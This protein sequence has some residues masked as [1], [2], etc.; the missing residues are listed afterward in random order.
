MKKHLSI[1]CGVYYP[2]PSPT[3]LCAKHFAQLL[4]DDYDIDMICLSTNGKSE[5]VTT[6]D[7]VRV[8]TLSGKRMA[9][10]YNSS[11]LMK[12]VLHMLG[13]IQIK[14]TVLGNLS[15]FRTAIYKE[16]SYIHN[17]RPFD[18]IFSIC[19]PF[20]AHCAAMDFK[21]EYP[22]V[23][24]CA[25]T[26]DPYSAQNRRR[27]FA[28]SLE[29]LVNAERSVLAKADVLL[30]SEEVYKTRGELYV[31]HRNYRA[32]PYMLP[33]TGFVSGE[34]RF[35]NAQ[36]I[37]CVYAGRFY[38]DIRNPEPMLKAFTKLSDNRIKLH[39]FSKGCEGIVRKYAGLSENL[40]IHEQVPHDEIAEVYRDADILV[41]VS[42]AVAEFLPS[43]TFEYIASCKPIIS[44]Q[45]T[46][47]QNELLNAYPAVIQVYGTP[48]NRVI[49]EL[50]DFILTQAHVILQPKTIENIYVAHRKS[51]I[52]AIVADALSACG[53]YSE[54]DR[55]STIK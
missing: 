14:T 44:F 40:I 20:P 39:L 5:D 21:A 26:V 41:S 38:E 27:P 4:L 45:Q 33:K 17:Q 23:R 54:N 19:S 55:N 15:W 42:N 24:W 22:A 47:C 37:N 12:K 46:N 48:D 51:S 13:G 50:M 43:K 1:I 29:K 2:E 53:L 6:G 31:G 16:L 34:R 7:G 11:G 30:L 49:C 10:E 9:L 18:A 3:G 25:Y 8:H 28:Y 32:L 35:F 36:D 52:A